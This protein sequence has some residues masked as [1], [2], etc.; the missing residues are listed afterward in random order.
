MPNNVK[1]IGE[2]AFNNC[3]GL[4]SITLPNSVMSIGVGAFDGCI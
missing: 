3:A 2:G 1:E 4:T